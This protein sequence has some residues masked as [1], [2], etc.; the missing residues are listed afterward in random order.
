MPHNRL[1]QI[2]EI[3]QSALTL[4]PEER[5][6]FVCK[7]TDDPE[8]QREIEKLLVGYK[9]AGNFN[10]QNSDDRFRQSGI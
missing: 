5:L 8:L 3:F 6:N 2:E 4:A 9:S 7:C 1:H 10:E